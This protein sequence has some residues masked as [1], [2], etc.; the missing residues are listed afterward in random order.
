M[1]SVH[2]KYEVSIS[3]ISKVIARVKVDDKQTGQKQYA[4]DHSILGQ[5]NLTP[6]KCSNL[7]SMRIDAQK[8]N[9]QIIKIQNAN[10]TCK[11]QI[12]AIRAKVE[13]VINVFISHR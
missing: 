13:N 10:M 2:A 4:P 11:V 6:W 5:K 3:Y 7:T 8:H 1:R 9:D 12:K